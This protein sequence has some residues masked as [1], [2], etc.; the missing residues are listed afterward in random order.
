VVAG[1]TE[2]D[3][4]PLPRVNSHLLLSYC[5]GLLHCQVPIL[6]DNH[7]GRFV[8]RQILVTDHHRC[9]A[10]LLQWPD[11]ARQAGPRIARMGAYIQSQTGRIAS[12][13]HLAT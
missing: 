12:D 2:N 3:S 1:W 7:H 11:A 13:S 9:G 6:I 10:V 4:R 8:P 5:R